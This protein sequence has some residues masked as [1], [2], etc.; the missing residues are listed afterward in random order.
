M[1]KDCGCGSTGTTS[2]KVFVVPGMMCSNCENTVN[3]AARGLS[4]VMESKVD[5]KTKEVT[6][7]FDHT[8]TSVDE[9]K[10]AID[11]TGFEVEAVKDAPHHHNHGVI[12]KIK[13]FFS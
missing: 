9:I 2:S 10:A 12:S 7:R 11:A 8:K 3:T 4:G 13:G 5:L 6:I 1:C